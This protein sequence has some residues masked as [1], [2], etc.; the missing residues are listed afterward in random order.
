MEYIDELCR[1]KP[2]DNDMK[3]T[4]TFI[5]TGNVCRSSLAAA[6]LEKM[7]RLAG[8]EDIEVNS[9]GTADIGSQPRDPIM[10]RLA[11]ARGY[12]LTGTSTH[13]TREAL[14]DADLILVITYTHLLEVQN[15]LPYYRWG[16][17]RLFND[18]CFGHDHPVE[19]PS[20]MPDAVYT[21]TF[22]HLEKGCRVIVEKL[23]EGLDVTPP[24]PMD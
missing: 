24:V 11:A 19:D 7:V 6:L 13:M 3:T 16:R 1:K 23:K 18:Y 2:K 15:Q 8:L 17:I 4:V 9:M 5:C 21:K 10:V 12:E 20:Y 22:E 14:L